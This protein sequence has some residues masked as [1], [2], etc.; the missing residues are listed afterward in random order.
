MGVGGVRVAV[1]VIR[2]WKD[3][4]DQVRTHCWNTLLDLQ[5]FVFGVFSADMNK[6]DICSIL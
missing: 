4:V 2:V 5:P 1:G 6:L 3:N